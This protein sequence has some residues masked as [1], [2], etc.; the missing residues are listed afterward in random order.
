MGKVEIAIPPSRIYPNNRLHITQTHLFAMISDRIPGLRVICDA[1]P[2]GLQ[3][4]WLLLHACVSWNWG[5]LVK[6]WSK[7]R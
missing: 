1:N 5:L 3:I 6:L 4:R 2:A 7:Y